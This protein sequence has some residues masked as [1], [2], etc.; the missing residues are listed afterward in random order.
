TLEAELRAY[1]PE[2]LDRPRI[3]LLNKVDVLPSEEAI[4][5]LQSRFRAEGIETIP[6]SAL[7]GRGLDELGARLTEFFGS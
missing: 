3:V 4:E 1:T 7:S 2:L 5:D 6:V